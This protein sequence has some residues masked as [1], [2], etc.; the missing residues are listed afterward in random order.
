MDLVQLHTLEP[1]SAGR[2]LRE[3]QPRLERRWLQPWAALA[4]SVAGPWRPADVWQGAIERLVWTASFTYPEGGFFT[5]E[6]EMSAGSLGTLARRQAPVHPA[7][8]VAGAFASA[9]VVWHSDAGRSAYA[10]VWRERRLRWSLRLDDGRGLVRCD[11]ERVVVESPPRHLPELDR[12]GVLLGGWQRFLGEP[13]PVEGTERLLLVDS[14]AG[15]T[16]AAEP[17][18]LFGR[19]LWDGEE[20]PLLARGGRA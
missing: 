18:R 16:H 11:G 13:L 4:V 3:L 19:G 7:E 12:T 9:L 10:A 20:E 14:L 1:L 8:I 2:L 6:G 15:L 17:E 5:P